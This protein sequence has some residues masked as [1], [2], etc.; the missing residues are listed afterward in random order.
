MLNALISL[1]L[2]SIDVV[3]YMHL[4]ITK[5]YVFKQCIFIITYDFGNALIIDNSEVQ[6][7]LEV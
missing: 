2:K 4:Y 5:I 1:G 3:N 6:D 7:S